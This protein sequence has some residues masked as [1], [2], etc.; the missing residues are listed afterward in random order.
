MTQEQAAISDPSQIQ[1]EADGVSHALRWHSEAGNSAPRKVR[2][3]DDQMAADTAYR[4]ACEGTA[5]LWQGDFTSQSGYENLHAILRSDR[6]PTAVF[7]CN[8]LMAIGALCA[9]HE[10]GVRV[11]DQLSVVGFDDIELARFA[12]P[13]LT[14]VAQPKQRIGALAVDMLIE[15]VSGRRHEDRTVVLEPELVVRSSTA[16]VDSPSRGSTARASALPA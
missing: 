9:A 7:V 13:P 14:T 2:L 11:P 6:R 8:D 15:R 5:L 16:R 4:L 12:S 10:G 1:W 3:A